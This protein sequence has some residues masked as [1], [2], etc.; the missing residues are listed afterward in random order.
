MTG[1]FKF[2]VIGSSGV[3]KTAIL[4]RLVDDV[5]TGESQSTI[6]VEFLATSVNVDGK[7][8]KLQIWD[9]AG[10]ERFRSIAKA[11]FRSAVGVML[12]FDLT[13]RKSFEDLNNWLGDVHTLCDPNAVITLIGNKSDLHDSRAISGAE[14]ESFAHLHQL[15]YLETSAKGGDNV[16]EAFQRTAAAVY[17]RSLAD[18]PKIDEGHKIGNTQE[19]SSCC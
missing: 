13:E 10:Q 16:Q 12:V 2:I 18:S 9:T 3:G 19:N 7:Q 11:Y 1:N 5:F 8:V 6:G 14:A 17:R 15:Y 4:K